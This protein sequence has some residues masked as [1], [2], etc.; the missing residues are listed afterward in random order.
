MTTI[1]YYCAR[2]TH[3]HYY[4]AA[5]AVCPSHPDTA[6]ESVS[7]ETALLNHFSAIQ[8]DLHRLSEALSNRF[9]LP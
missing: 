5:T 8:E 6:L 7:F 2:C 9:E 3:P 1:R 4:D